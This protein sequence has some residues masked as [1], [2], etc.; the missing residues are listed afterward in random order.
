MKLFFDEPESESVLSDGHYSGVRLV[1]F[2]S[3]ILWLWWL[4]AATFFNADCLWLFLDFSEYLLLLFES[5]TIRMYYS[6]KN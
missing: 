4:E 5:W 2:S 6:F 1:I 3:D